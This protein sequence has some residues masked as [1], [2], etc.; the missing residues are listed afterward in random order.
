M[1]ITSDLGQREY[2]SKF[3]V[4]RRTINKMGVTRICLVKILGLTV[5]FV[6]TNT[7]T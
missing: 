3:F 4:L 7:L 1:A 6:N 5:Y 2:T